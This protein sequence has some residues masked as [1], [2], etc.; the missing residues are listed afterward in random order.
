MKSKN[1]LSFLLIVI[2]TAIAYL[3][4][5]YATCFACDTWVAL[6]NSTKDGSVIIG[7]N[8]DRPTLEAQPLVYFPRKNVVIYVQVRALE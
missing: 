2:V 5:Y 6:G 8:S 3:F 4:S 1:F 7:K